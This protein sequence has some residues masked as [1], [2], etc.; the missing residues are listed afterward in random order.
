MTQNQL[1]YWANQ[2]TARANLA[3][4]TE[5]NRHN[6]ADETETHR[7]NVADETERARS[8]RARENET[9][10]SNLRNEQIKQDKQDLDAW[11]SLW[12]KNGI[13]SGNWKQALQSFALKQHDYKGRP[14]LDDTYFGDI[15]NSPSFKVPQAGAQ[16]LQQLSDGMWKT[17][18]SVWDALTKAKPPDGLTPK[19]R[20]KRVQGIK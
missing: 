2:E 8:N 13:Y 10:R 15:Q 14:V 19:E 4:E 20:F 7:A 16:G 5:T 11:N 6:V 12:G 18:Q 9:N 17:G 3:R 1:T